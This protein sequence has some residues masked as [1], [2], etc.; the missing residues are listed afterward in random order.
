MASIISPTFLAGKFRFAI[1]KKFTVPTCEIG[2]KSF[3]GLIGE[4]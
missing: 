2:T 4:G 1:R 3:S